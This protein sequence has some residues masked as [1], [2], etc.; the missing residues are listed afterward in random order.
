MPSIKVL[1]NDRMA[2]RVTR[3]QIAIWGLL[4]IMT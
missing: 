4:G 1:D 2:Q 3:L